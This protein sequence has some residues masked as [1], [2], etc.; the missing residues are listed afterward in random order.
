[1]EEHILRAKTAKIGKDTEIQHGAVI[2]GKVI[3]GSHCFVGYYAII[4]EGSVLED[5]VYVGAR[6]LF[7][8]TKKI[9]HRR[10]Y[11]VELGGPHVGYGARIASGAILLPGVKIGKNA[12]VGSGALIAHDVPEREI[13]FGIPAKKRGNVPDEECVADPVKTKKKVVKK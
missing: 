3:I 10:S 1:M 4:S 6:S 5:N 13:H 7:V 8:S 12:L 11:E 9:A 2:E